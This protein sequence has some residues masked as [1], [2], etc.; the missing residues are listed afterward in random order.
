MKETQYLWDKLVIL[1][2]WSRVQL[3]KNSLLKQSNHGLGFCK[4]TLYWAKLAMVVGLNKQ[5]SKGNGRFRNE[6]KKMWGPTESQS[7][8]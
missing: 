2:G 6:A 5:G 1:Y 7:F 3:D 8:I 4:T